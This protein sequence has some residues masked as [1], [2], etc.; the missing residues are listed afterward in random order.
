MK[1]SLK[2]LIFIFSVNCLLDFNN[3]SISQL[4]SNTLLLYNKCKEYTKQKIIQAEE[5]VKTMY[6]KIKGD[7]NLKVTKTEFIE[8][9]ENNTSDIGVKENLEHENNKMNNLNSEYDDGNSTSEYNNKDYSNLND[10]D[11]GVSKTDNVNAEENNLNNNE[12]PQMPK[13]FEKIF[14]EFFEMFK[15]NNFSPN[16]ENIDLSEENESIE[17]GSAEEIDKDNAKESE[18]EPL[19]KNKNIKEEL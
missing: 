19:E 2:F 14:K 6:Y 8:N 18:E 1:V 7:K 5:K 3:N 15:N 4:Y 13:D 16:E 12:Q 17:N 11:D 10:K 9:K